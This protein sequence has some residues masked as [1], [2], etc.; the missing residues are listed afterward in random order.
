MQSSYTW[1]RN[2]GTVGNRWH[3]NA[4]RFDLG[5]P[6][7][8]DEPNRTINAYGRATFDPTH[9][10]KVLSTYRLPLWGGTTLSGVYRYSTGQA[11]GRT[12]TVTGLTQ[13][14]RRI[15]VEPAGTR[16]A[17]AID[18]LDLRVEKTIQLRQRGSS[19]GI[20][21]DVFNVW[22][23]GVPNS[24]ADMAIVD[25]S[26]ARFGEPNTWVDPRMLRLGLR[27]TF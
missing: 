9:E 19:I 8:F 13:G 7:R 14:Q 3:V 6:G 18:R 11:W 16:R 24:D 20:F 25:L 21:A 4:A 23:Q 10:I 26:G 17:P 2:R 22:N 15:R 1:S 12:A 5:S 27:L